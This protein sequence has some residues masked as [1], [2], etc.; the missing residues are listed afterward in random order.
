[1]KNYIVFL[2]FS[3]IGCIS[4]AN[5]NEKS[6]FPSNTSNNFFQMNGRYQLINSNMSVGSGILNVPMVIDTETG[7]VWYFRPNYDAKG[8]PSGGWTLVPVP[9]GN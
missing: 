8:K 3:L 5:A 1:M 9:Y 4:I 6:I 2:I 7:K